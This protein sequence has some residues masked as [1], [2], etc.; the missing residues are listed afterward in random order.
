MPTK[1]ENRED[2]VTY[3]YGDSPWRTKILIISRGRIRQDVKE[4]LKTNF[5]VSSCEEAAMELTAEVCLPS[6]LQPRAVLLEEGV[7]EENELGAASSA[8]SRLLEAWSL[9]HVLFLA[10]S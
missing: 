6:P 8:H 5:K 10:F 7:A 1:P 9:L 4:Q 3:G 2:T